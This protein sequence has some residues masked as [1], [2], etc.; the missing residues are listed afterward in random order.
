EEGDNFSYTFLVNG[1]SYNVS[2]SGLELRENNF[3][4]SGVLQTDIPLSK[5]EIDNIVSAE[6]TG[7]DFSKKLLVEWSDESKTDKRAFTIKGIEKNEMECTLSVKWNGKQLGISS[8]DDELFAGEQTFFIPGAD[9]FSVVSVDSSEAQKIV[10]SFSSELNHEQ[11][12]SYLMD[13]KKRN[14]SSLS[15]VRHS[16]N[17]N[18]LTLFDDDNWQNISSIV[19]SASIQNVNGDT[20][21]KDYEIFMPSVWQ[22]PSVQFSTDGN[23]LPTTQGTNLAIETRNLTGISLRV[24]EIYNSNMLQF[25]QQNELDGSYDLSYVAEAVHSEHIKFEWNDSMQNVFVPRGIDLSNLVKKYPE[26]MFRIQLAFS[27]DDIQYACSETHKDFSHL[28]NPPDNTDKNYS[29]DLQWEYLNK[30]DWTDRRD[31]WRYSKD[32]C[33]PAFYLEMYGENFKTRNVLV[34]DIGL[35]AKRTDDGD[36]HVAVTNL[37]T[38]SP[39]KDV[40]VTLYSKINRQ[41][42]QA[43]SDSNGFAIFKNAKDARVVVATINNQASYL[44]LSEGAILSMS[45]FETGGQ[46]LQQGAKGYIYGEWG[47]WRPGDELF[48]TFV[49]QDL[50]KKFP[51]EIPLTFELQ[52]PLG[53]IVDEQTL[54]NGVNGFYAIKTKTNADAKT[55]L[56]TAFVRFGGNE[57]SKNVRV[58]SIVPNHLEVKL[59]LAK[60]YLSAENN[61]LKLSGKW[62]HGSPTPNYKADV[63]M[64]LLSSKTEF[65]GY[66]SYT[67]DNYEYEVD[68]NRKTVWEGNL[69]DQSNTEINLE[70]RKHDEVP[71]KL[72]CQFISRIFEPSG[73]FS[74]SQETFDFSPFKRYV[75]LRLPEGKSARKILYTDE[76]NNVDVVLLTDDGKPVKDGKV[77]YSIYK[78]DWKWW[79]EKDSLTDA[80]FVSSESKKIVESDSLE[81]KNGKGSFSFK[82]DRKNWGR[83]F[84]VVQDDG[85]KHAASK[86]VYIDWPDWAGRTTSGNAGSASVVPL[87]TDKEQYVVGEV[88]SVSFATSEDSRA[89]IT[90]EKS[91]SIVKQEWLETKTGTTVYKLPLTEKMSPNVYVH[92]TLVQSHLQTKNSLPIRLYGVVP[93]LVENNA[94]RLNPIVTTP[95]SYEPGK[96]S[97]LTVAEKNGKP[98][99]FTVTV[100]DEGLLNI[101]NFKTPVLHDEFY[102]KES[103]L[104]ENWDLF[105]YVMNAYSGKLETILSIGGSEEILDASGKTNSRFTPVVRYFGPYE[106]K[107]NAKK[108]IEF[109]MPEYIGSVRTMVVAGNN[110]AYGVAEKQTPVKSELMI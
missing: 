65:S 50:E 2:L 75:G 99:T 51:K 16:V 8:K 100:V 45:H 70:L 55:G 20:L 58:E 43:K 42:L 18:V 31:F 22:V 38:A 98:M 1:P 7:E 85:G 109:E 79:W 96:K 5:K 46:K 10:V 34:S 94:T 82:I 101:T 67:F 14:S 97:M 64:R 56:Y 91:G 86:I 37:K 49:L 33:H 28:P 57:W 81:I 90:I 29:Y 77:I 88:A 13:V 61:K 25:L 108:E 19:I 6:I 63:S 53:K 95:A 93:L 72:K 80:T 71:G 66:S 87:T 24:F 68:S 105:G 102:K 59:E 107:A 74:Q 47:V 104:L 48:L 23:I 103:S 60:K 110:G 92:V 62:L 17:K 40:T 30:I 76:S 35:I 21:E 54:T 84:I 106:L 11:E 39:I 4:L 9:S 26:G 41:L 32:P 27:K 73:M 12:I 89:L 69:N 36:L 3:S 52:D 78:L 44:K 15:S 83:Y